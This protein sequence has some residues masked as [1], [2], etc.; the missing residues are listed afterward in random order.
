MKHESKYDKLME[1]FSLV[2]IAKSVGDF[3]STNYVPHKRHGNSEHAKSHKVNYF[4][5]Q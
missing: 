5:Q 4:K 2:S 1:D 3:Q